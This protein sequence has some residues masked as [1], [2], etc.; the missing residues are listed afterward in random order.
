MIPSPAR[1]ISAE[2]GLFYALRLRQENDKLCLFFVNTCGKLILK[3]FMAPAN[4]PKGCGAHVNL[5]VF[6]D[7]RGRI[8]MRIVVLG[9]GAMGGLYGSYLSRGNDV[10]MVDI[11]AEVVDKINREGFEVREPDGSRTCS[12]RRGP[13]PPRAWRR[14]TSSSSS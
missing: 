8:V 5:S 6:C 1:T 7:R 3:V 12:T 10:T 4:R 9:A 14:W 2:E 13:P 11:N